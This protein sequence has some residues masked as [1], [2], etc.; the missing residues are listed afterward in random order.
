MATV[1]VDE[2]CKLCGHFKVHH[3][4]NSCTMML[5]ERGHDLV[6]PCRCP[7]FVLQGNEYAGG[8][9]EIGPYPEARPGITTAHKLSDDVDHPAHYNSH[10][11]GIEA[12]DIVRHH[13]FNVGSAMKYLW[14]CGLKAGEPRLKELKKAVWYLQDEVAKLEREEKK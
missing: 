3:V 12:I 2:V 7:G 4:D 9:S 11:S 13:S 14:R 5:I 10:P 8:A 6:R 1:I